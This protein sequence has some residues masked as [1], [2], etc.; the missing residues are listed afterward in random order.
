VFGRLAAKQH[1]KVDAI[2]KGRR[3]TVY[4]TAAR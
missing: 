1:D 2:R 4:V 3:H